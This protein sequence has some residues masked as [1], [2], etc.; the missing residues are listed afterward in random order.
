MTD[1]LNKLFEDS[2]KDLFSAEKQFLKGMQK[3]AKAASAP[4]LKAAI[5]KHI[6]ET[7][8]HI[9]RLT[10]AAELL[11]IK[12][13]G[14]V[15]KAAQG[16][17]EEGEEHLEE[18]SPGPVLDAAIIVCSQKNEHYE[19]CSYG[20]MIAWA[21]QL[22]L[23]KVLTLLEQTLKEEKATDEALSSLAERSV[24]SMAAKGQSQPPT[25][26]ASMK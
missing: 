21:E 22:G 19:I 12:P 3:M 23:T 6:G 13:T 20:T 8:G 11:E 15:C 25:G 4:E 14:K 1:T 5:E 26:K 9:E 7:E 24:N 16:L 18:V 10:K 2:L 17:I